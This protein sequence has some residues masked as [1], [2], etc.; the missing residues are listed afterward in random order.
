[1]VLGTLRDALPTD[2]IAR[3]RIER[4][5]RRYYWLLSGALAVVGVVAMARPFVRRHGVRPPLPHSDTIILEYVGWFLA[6]GNTLYTDIWEIKPPLAFV[7]PYVLA[8]IT[9]TNMYAHH[10]GGMVLTGVATVAIVALAARIVGEASGSPTAGF[11]AGLSFFA[12]PGLFYQPWLGYKAKTLV[13]VFGLLSIDRASL[14]RPAES[15]L[16]AGLALGIWQLGIVFPLLTATWTWLDGSWRMRRRYLL[17]GCLAG[18][19]VL[20]ALVSLG[21]IEGFLAEVVLGPLVLQSDRPGLDPRLLFGYTPGWND[22]LLVVGVAG[23][24]LELISPRDDECRLLGAGG[25]LVCGVLLVDF[26]GFWDM[27][28]PLVFA[29]FGVGLLVSRLATRRRVLA[30]LFLAALLVP[31]FAPSEHV[32]HDP[33]VTEPSDGR[34]PSLD[35]GREHVYWTRQPI[36]SCRFF[37]ARTQRSILRYDP[38][39]DTLAASPCGRLDPYLRALS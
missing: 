33:V 13:F 28:Y 39:A 12:I 27:L 37:G 1:M 21:D 22:A 26:D 16:T 32:R 23:L 30:V 34:P 2:R 11:A 5:W 3:R 24:G 14:G 4:R 31:T 6:Q 20:L 8:E 18:L 25:L 35:P 7:P 36:E 29:A 9:G 10:L 15:G 17:G 19:S 38:D